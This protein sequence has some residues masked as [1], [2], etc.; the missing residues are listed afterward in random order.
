M[1]NTHSITLLNSY[2]IYL[3]VLSGLIAGVGFF[4]FTLFI[5]MSDIFDQTL[6]MNWLDGWRYYAKIVILFLAGYI[7]MP[8]GGFF[9]GRYG[10]IHGRKS[11]LSIS[12]IGVGIFTLIASIIPLTK[13]LDTIIPLLLGLI[14]FG[15]GIALGGLIPTIWAFISEHLPTKHLGVGCG[16]I[17]AGSLLGSLLAF[18]FSANL[19]NALTYDQ[20][21]LFGWRLPFLI[22][23]SLACFLLL[24]VRNLPETPIFEQIHTPNYQQP[25]HPISSIN[26]D[27]PTHQEMDILLNRHP[28]EPTNGKA[29]SFLYSITKKYATYFLPAFILSWQIFSLFI[30][31]AILLPQ[32]INIGFVIKE[33]Y[34]HIGAIISMF[35]MILGSLFYGFL[36]DRFNVGKIIIMG[37]IFLLLQVM[38]FFGH[39]KSGGEFILVF[40]ALLGFASGIIASSPVV[41]VRIFP[42]KIRLSGVALTINTAFALMGSLL[43]FFLNY[44][45]FSW[46]LTPALYLTFVILVTI[47]ISFHIYYLPNTETD[48]QR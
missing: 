47:F 20:I 37:S 48:M 16:L 31:I 2:H 46:R 22:G 25:K 29:L 14:R 17:M 41:I 24:L 4:D 6:F 36:T 34:L 27:D 28:L 45:T 5:Y 13:Q 23:G 40:F 30:I 35:F 43:P 18:V 8:L 19:E 38:L 26:L 9:I 12:L 42:A 10:D 11:A 44:T 32:L 1:S 3:I 21:M 39:L 15:Q 33:Y 7:G